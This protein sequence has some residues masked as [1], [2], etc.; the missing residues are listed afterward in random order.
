MGAHKIDLPLLVAEAERAARRLAEFSSVTPL[1]RSRL[2]ENETG[3]RQVYLKL[4][5][6]QPT[7]SCKIRSAGNMMLANLNEI[8]ERKLRIVTASTGNNA[9]AHGFLCKHF[10]VHGYAFLPELTD[11]EKALEVENSGLDVRFHGTDI[12]ESEKE[13]QRFAN[14]IGAIYHSPYNDHKAI[15]GQATIAREITE[16]LPSADFVFVTVGG[17]GLAAGISGYLRGVNYGARVIGCLPKASPTMAA[18][19]LARKIVK[20]P[21]KP[22]ISDSA[23]GIEEGSITFDYCLQLLHDTVLV[24]EDEIKRAMDYICHI[25]EMQVRR[26]RRKVEGAGAIPVAALLQRREMLRGRVV[27]LCICGANIGDTLFN[28][29]I[30]NYSVRDGLRR[31]TWI[32]EMS[33]AE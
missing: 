30:S 29:C 15:A 28:E 31:L 18:S 14:K 6:E 13:A 5:T 27:V 3:A 23:G 2:L 33:A 26:M 12:V 19:I 10:K 16:Q 4:E 24:S 22:S 8:R 11:R 1:I 20:V 32:P 9:I 21:Q 17:G 7:G 25:E